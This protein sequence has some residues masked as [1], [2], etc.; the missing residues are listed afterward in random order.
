[1]ILGG[2]V[3]VAIIITNIFTREKNTSPEEKPKYEVET[4]M[5]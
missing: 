1:M 3:L 4:V 5:G 2:I